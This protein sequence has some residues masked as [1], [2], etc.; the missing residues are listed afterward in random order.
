M[1][2]LVGRHVSLVRLAQTTHITGIGNLTTT[3]TEDIKSLGKA[4]LTYIEG[5][6]VHLQ[7]GKVEAVLP[8]GN[9]V[10]I[11]LKP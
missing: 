11:E 10:S 3:I 1:E 5:G 7:F 6:H 9:I 2:S 8:V 4:V